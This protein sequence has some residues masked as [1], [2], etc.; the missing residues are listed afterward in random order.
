MTHEQIEVAV[1]VIVDPGASGS[2]VYSAP[3]KSGFLGYVG[4]RSLAVVME[5]NILPVA[6]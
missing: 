4:K 2:K 3:G 1:A 6:K 5:Q